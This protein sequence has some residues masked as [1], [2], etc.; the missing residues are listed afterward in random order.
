MAST[1]AS[2][3]SAVVVSGCE[4]NKHTNE[5]TRKKQIAITNVSKLPH[6]EHLTVGQL[7]SLC[8]S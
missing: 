3:A 1:S 4:P 5:Q 6:S 8:I 2:V 7:L